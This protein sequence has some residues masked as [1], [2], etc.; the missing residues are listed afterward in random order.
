MCQ[1]A[2][3]AFISKKPAA[4][5]QRIQP[6]RRRQQS[7]VTKNTDSSNTVKAQSTAAA[8]A[9]EAEGISDITRP[10]GCFHAHLDLQAVQKVTLI[11]LEQPL[12]PIQRPAIQAITELV[13]LHEH[14]HPSSRMIQVERNSCLGTSRRPADYERIQRRVPNEHTLNLLQA[15]GALIQG[16]FRE[17][18]NYAV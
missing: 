10:R 5:R 16:Q 2:L 3:Y 14:P 1:E 8:T 7:T 17:V 18:V 13:Y 15:L 11:S 9:A 12:L 6:F 4:K